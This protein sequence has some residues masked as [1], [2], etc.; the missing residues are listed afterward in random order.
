MNTHAR[1]SYLWIQWPLDLWLKR[2]SKR[3]DIRVTK[4]L[5]L[6]AVYI[7]GFETKPAN[8]AAADVLRE[9]YSSLLAEA[10]PPETEVN[11]DE[12]GTGQRKAIR[13]EHPGAGYLH[14]DPAAV[15][16]W[17]ETCCTSLLEVLYSDP[18]DDLPALVE[19]RAPGSTVLDPDDE[20]LEADLAE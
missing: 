14:G 2:Y 8:M 15:A 9:R 6:I 4:E 13:L 3:L 11:W 5:A 20:D 10:L 17:A 19:A 18:V 1:G 12:V 16:S 7:T